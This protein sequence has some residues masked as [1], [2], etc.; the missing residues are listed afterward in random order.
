MGGSSNTGGAIL[1]QYFNNDEI[2]KYTRLLHPETS[3]GLNYYPLAS[4]GER[5]PI[6]DP[7]LLPKLEPRPDSDAIFFQ[8]ILEGISDIETRGYELLHELG[9]PY[10][11]EV[12]T[13]GGGAINTG[14][15]NIRANQ[16]G[17]KVNPAKHSEAAF[18]AALLAS[19]NT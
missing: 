3:T 13:V 17:V 12:I 19:T 5:F 1:K 16:L 9:A 2:E 14:W 6:N 18:G 7:E 8:G 10:P 4:I 15:A 11:S